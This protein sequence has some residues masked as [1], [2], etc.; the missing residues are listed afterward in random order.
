M[1]ETIQPGGDPI[2]FR[3]YH[4]D[5]CFLI[6]SQIFHLIDSSLLQ[7]FHLYQYVLTFT[8]EIIAHQQRCPVQTVL[9]VQPLHTAEEYDKYVKRSEEERIAREEVK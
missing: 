4:K 9:P 1:S 7:H 3:I 2:R 6:F 8:P 5:V